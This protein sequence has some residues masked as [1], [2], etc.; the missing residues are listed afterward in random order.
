LY[1]GL[2]HIPLRDRVEPKGCR[3]KLS[4][5]CNGETLLEKELE[6]GSF[7]KFVRELEKQSAKWPPGNHIVELRMTFS[8][9][10][11]VSD[12]IKSAIRDYVAHRDPEQDFIGVIGMSEGQINAEIFE[13]FFPLFEKIFLEQA[14]EHGR[15]PTRD[16][17]GGAFRHVWLGQLRV[18]VSK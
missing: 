4:H 10:E 7:W 11:K 14:K 9:P 16:E 18:W 13:K 15:K 17:F 1:V 12:E 5:R 8:L 3:Y 2:K 6:P